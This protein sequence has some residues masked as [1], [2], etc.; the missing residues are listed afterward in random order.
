MKKK[1]DTNLAPEKWALSLEIT[2]LWAVFLGVLIAALKKFPIY[3]WAWRNED[4][5]FAIL[6][7]VFVAFGFLHLTFSSF[8][9]GLRKLRRSPT[10]VRSKILRVTLELIFLNLFGAAVCLGVTLLNVQ[11]MPQPVS[12]AFAELL[13]LFFWIAA[14][15]AI[16]GKRH[17]ELVEILNSEDDM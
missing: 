15:T 3:E 8:V 16:S 10:K 14:C 2:L 7:G 1:P 6:T 11:Y 12:A 9:L 5:F 17:N 13:L 4:T